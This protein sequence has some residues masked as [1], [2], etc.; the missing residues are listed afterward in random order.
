MALQNHKIEENPVRLFFS[1]LCPASRKIRMILGEM[2]IDHI[3][4]EERFVSKSDHLRKVNYE[5][6]VPVLVMGGATLVREY[7][8]QE[9][10]GDTPDGKALVGET[11]SERAEVRRLASWFDQKFS[12][13]I[14]VPVMEEKVLKRVKGRHNPN[15][16]LLKEARHNLYNHMDYISWLVDRRNWLAGESLSL[17]DLAAA[18]H[19]SC[20]DYLGDVP[21]SRYSAAKEWYVRIKSR[22]SFRPILMETFVGLVPAPHYRLLDF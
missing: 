5:A 6:T 4:Y 21:W 3:A 13:E 2:G 12:L 14:T 10:L 15:S 19:L 9:F 20:L 22:P 7:A 11:A 8:I 18:S 17:A 16:T 1:A